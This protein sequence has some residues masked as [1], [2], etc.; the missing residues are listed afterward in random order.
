VA[1]LLTQQQ[2]TGAWG[3][4]LTAPGTLE[5][6]AVTLHALCLAS[7]YGSVP[8]ERLEISAEWL[9]AATKNG[10]SFPPA[11]IGLYFARLW[12][13]EQLYPIIWTTQALTSVLRLRLE[14]HSN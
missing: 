5:E 11:P 4:D 8:Q 7:S 9:L 6:T 1:Y 14:A 3:G 2:A 12:Y 13:H 10:T